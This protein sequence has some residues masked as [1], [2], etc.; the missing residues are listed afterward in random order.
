[1]DEELQ[2]DIHRIV[3]SDSNL[4]ILPND[5]AAR[6]LK[7]FEDTY[8]VKADSLWWWECLKTPSK[9]V[10]YDPDESLDSLKSLL[11]DKE[12][13]LLLVVTDDDSPPW[14]VIEGKLD[15]L[16]KLVEDLRYFEYFV[17]DRSTRWIVF[18]THHNQ[19][20]ITNAST[21]E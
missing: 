14:I 1:M 5:E 13:E 4:R 2:R 21:S 15:H 3:G 19:F 10:N 11:S 12:G 8:V 17:A 6:L 7:T 9:S 20:V 18:D 16:M